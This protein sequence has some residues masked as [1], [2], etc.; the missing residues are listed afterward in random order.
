MAFSADDVALMAD[1]LAAA[2]EKTTA[3]GAPL[4]QVGEAALSCTSTT[5]ARLQLRPL[6]SGRPSAEGRAFQTLDFALNA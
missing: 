2:T 5:S 1:P 4:A 6:A 3:T